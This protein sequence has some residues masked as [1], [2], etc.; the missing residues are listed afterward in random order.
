M[1][2]DKNKRHR[3]WVFTWNNWTPENLEAI[4][5]SEK[6][7]KYC[8]C[9]DEVGEQGTPHLQGYFELKS[10]KTLSACRKLLPGCGY[11]WPA[12]ADGACNKSYCEK[13]EKVLYEVGTPNQQGARNDLVRLSNHVKDG[14]TIR[15]M[16]EDGSVVNCQQLNVAEKLM[17]YMEPARDRDC[18]PKII[19]RY[20][21][22][23]CGKTRWVYEEYDDVFVP[24]SSKWWE[25]YD[26]H[27]TV[28]IDDIRDD[29]CTWS[30]FLKL[31]DR[32][33]M[34]VE[35]KGSS[36]QLQAST[37]VITSPIAPRDAWPEVF[38]ERKQLYRRITE[39]HK[40]FADGSYD[41]VESDAC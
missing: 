15:E 30:E 28:L 7:F 1:E 6:Q 16:I 19:W 2:I 17:K 21:P 14:N 9:G 38:E 39:L 20:G 5:K 41:V 23:G 3:S 22:A 33:A 12:K 25:G 36:R 8:V 34:R 18:P 27:K 31:T 26:G 35:S 40:C 37:I 13:G 32:Y 29:W 4:K 24:T 11:L 10:A